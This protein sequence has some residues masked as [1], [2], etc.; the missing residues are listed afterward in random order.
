[1]TGDDLINVF[2]EEAYELLEELEIVLIEMEDQTGSEE[3]LNRAFRAMH[4]LK[5]SAGLAGLNHISDF[6]HH[7]ED[8]LD[9][10]RNKQLEVNERIINLL[11]RSCD[12]VLQMVNEIGSIESSINKQEI[13]DLQMEMMQSLQNTS[14]LKEG[15]N[16]TVRLTENRSDEM[17]YLIK[18]DLNNGFFQT[19]TDLLLLLEELNNL[20]EIIETNI[21]IS[22]IPELEIIDPEECYLYFTIIFKTRVILKKIKDVFMFI[23]LDNKILIEDIS[24]NFKGGIDLSLANKKFG[25]I[26]VEKRIIDQEII[27]DALSQQNRIGELLIKKGSI[28]GKQVSSIIEKQQQSKQLQEKSTIKIDIEKLE[29]LMNNM[30]E[31]IIA[32]AKVKNLAEIE[33]KHN[34][35]ELSIALD[36]V[37]KRIKGLQEEIMRARMVPIG[38]TFMRFRRLIR[39]LSRELGK[40]IN[41]DI[42]G[43]DTELDKKVIEKIVDPLKHII[44]NSID[45]GLELPEEREKQGKD[46][47]GKI[48]L[49]A[50]HK[51]GNVVIEIIDNGRGLDKDRILEEAIKKGVVKPGLELA[52]NDLYQLICEPGFSTSRKVTDISGRGVGMDVVKSNVEQLRGNLTIS[53][54]KGEGTTVKIKLP[55]TLAIIDGMTV[56]VGKEFFIIPLNSITEFMQFFPEN[57]K[58]IKGKKELLKVRDEPIVLSKLYKL[59]DLEPQNSETSRGIV[60]IV[61]DDDKKICLLVDEII[62]QQQVVVKSLEDNFTNIEG[63]AGGTILGNGKV[64][65]ILDIGS[66]MR[67]AM[68]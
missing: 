13:I 30:A 48:T 63:I 8:L 33:I 24:D 44:R 50:Y 39:D 45:H 16:G 56:K 22:R 27:E 52:D 23:E 41:L 43:K 18:L 55:L 60:I 34:N 3:L 28:S 9:Q 6:I 37:D 25:E 66:V 17:V 35:D 61:N 57:I 38:A 5:G 11:L 32:Q 1:M 65:M 49:N 10:C 68:K 2:I 53:S 26:L 4:T 62:G 21:N 19:G 54:K 20:G 47:Q 64:A 59:F 40:E 12:M 58:T 15:K 7:A 29:K 51:E 42:K 36:V 14:E 31:L 46:R 67:L